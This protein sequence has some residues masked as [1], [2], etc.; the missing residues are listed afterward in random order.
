[1]ACRK[2]CCGRSTIARRKRRNGTVFCMIPT[3]Y[4]WPMR[5]TIPT[6]RNSARRS[7]SR[8]ARTMLRRPI[9]HF[10]PGNPTPRSLPSG[11]GLETSFTRVDNGRIKWVAVDLP[12]S[13]A[14][15]L[16]FL[17]DTPRHR[18]VACSALDFRWMDAVD[19]SR[20]VV[21]TA[22][23]LLMYFEPAHVRE[24]IR[25]CA[26]R[27]AGGWLIFDTIH[28]HTATTHFRAHK[29]RQNSLPRNAL[30]HRCGSGPRYRAIFTPISSTSKRLTRRPVSNGVPNRNT[31]RAKHLGSWAQPNVLYSRSFRCRSPTTVIGENVNCPRPIVPMAFT[32]P[33]DQPW[34]A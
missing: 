27:F 3:P 22:Q 23:G 11:D 19:V 32:I 8:T 7:G 1:M 15:R 25:Q 21:V 17:P 12:E 5:S 33:A 31:P 9:R 20:G 4:V 30:G 13:I 28:S 16:Q 2:L 6:S 24:L 18:N 26:G 34:I 14:L 29:R 10:C